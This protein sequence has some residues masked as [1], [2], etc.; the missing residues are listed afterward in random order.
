MRRKLAKLN[1]KPMA[2]KPP[3]APPAGSRAPETIVYARD[4]PRD[5][6]RR[7]AEGGGICMSLEDCVEGIEERSPLGPP[8]FLLER[9]MT[10]APEEPEG[11]RLPAMLAEALE[12]LARRAAE[13]GQ[14]WTV[15]PQDVCFLDLETTGLGCCPVFLIGTLVWRDGDLV[16]RQ[17]LARTYAEE[18]SI[19]GAFAEQAG[20]AAM[21]VTF[22]GKT[23][24][25]PFLRTRAAATG[26]PLPEPPG[27]FDLLHESRRTFGDRLPNCKLTT[28]ERHVCQRQRGDDIPGSDIPAAY[29]DFVRSG[30]ARQ[31]AL[32]VKH[33]QWDLVTMVHL[34]K[35]VLGEA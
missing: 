30:D 20:E 32:I 19:V 25:V 11:G 24:D 5:Q 7:V 15:A 18:R 6:P 27:H 35:R 16:C 28:L 2:D 17:Y 9:S 12:T 1:R 3:T 14:A 34:M 8:F 22:N 26:V 29:H 23:F 33:N 13:A 31:I 21:L 4:L 10:E